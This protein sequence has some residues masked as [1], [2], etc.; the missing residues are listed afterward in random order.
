MNKIHEKIPTNKQLEKR[1]IIEK[2][3]GYWNQQIIRVK[4]AI[5]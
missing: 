1:T 4:N 3:L 5:L 2:L